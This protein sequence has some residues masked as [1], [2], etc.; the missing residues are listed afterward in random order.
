MPEICPNRD[1]G[2]RVGHLDQPAGNSGERASVVPQTADGEFHNRPR[3]DRSREV[4]IRRAW[5]TRI[6]IENDDRIDE[7]SLKNMVFVFQ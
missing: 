5:G 3:S 6:R 4:S 7:S 2:L 1:T